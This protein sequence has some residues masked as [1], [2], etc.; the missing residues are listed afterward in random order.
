MTVYKMDKSK[1]FIFVVIVIAVVV[2]GYFYAERRYKEGYD[3]GYNEAYSKGYSDGYADKGKLTENSTVKTETKVVYQTIPY[4]GNDV[5]VTTEKPKVTVSINGKK[6]EIEQKTET[7]DLQ[8]KTESEVKIKI[9][10]RK[11]KFGIGT[12]GKRVTY[13]VSTPAPFVTND[14]IGLWVA[15][16]KG[17]VMGGVSVSF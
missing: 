4:N 16:T 5:Q 13:M 17:K 10:E 14:A 6:Q 1:L 7:A 15:G 8:V 2:G 12:D 3:V 11:Y 9:P